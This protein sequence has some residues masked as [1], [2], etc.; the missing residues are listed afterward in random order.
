MTAIEPYEVAMSYG[1]RPIRTVMVII[2]NGHAYVRF[3][4]HMSATANLKGLARVR[5]AVHSLFT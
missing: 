5:T 3:K 4:W 2:N 1:L